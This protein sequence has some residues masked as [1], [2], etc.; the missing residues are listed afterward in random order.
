[1]ADNLLNTVLGDTSTLISSG[2]FAGSQATLLTSGLSSIATGASGS[3]LASSTSGVASALS[4]TG[5]SGLASSLTGSVSGLTSSITGSVSGLASSLTGKVSGLASSL[6][7]GIAIPGVAGLLD[8]TK[9]IAGAA[10]G[11]ITSSFKSFKANVPQNL[12]AIAT[13]NEADAKSAD[14]LATAK[15]AASEMMN[16]SGIGTA[17]DKISSVGGSLVSGAASSLSGAASGIV[18]GISNVVSIA[19]N[20]AGSGISALAGGASAT[21]LLV[22][23][24]LGSSSISLPGVSGITDIIKTGTSA[25][26]NGVNSV[27]SGSISG[28]PNLT[29]LTGTALTAATSLR[30]KTQSLASLATTGLPPSAAA[31]L[32]SA[33]S[34]ISS[35]GAIPIKLPTIATST[36]DRGE[37]TAGLL[38]AFGSTKI[39]VPNFAGN[40]ATF[41]KT[42]SSELLK[43][44]DESKVEIAKLSDEY[45]AQNI[46]IRNA[47]GAYQTAKN[48]LPQG[49]PT[50]ETLKATLLTEQK[51]LATIDTKIIA[52]RKQQS[53]TA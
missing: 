12:T 15:N 51:T 47:Q 10:F 48:D 39:P 53:L 42:A 36:L 29:G 25:S 4:A 9:G 43:K 19:A 14:I 2:T 35:G 41:G 26:T 20:G 13:K 40:P 18:G 17:I 46:K 30:D 50:I 32:Q 34:S 11:A 37:L 21:A 6:T 52:L 28:L 3:L 16:T 33:M 44:Y 7:G 38:A 23:N 49:D 45:L 24:T 5:V 31:T 1:M 8:M 27:L 22:S